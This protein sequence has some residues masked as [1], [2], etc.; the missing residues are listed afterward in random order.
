LKRRFDLIESESI[1]RT[2]RKNYL[3]STSSTSKTSHELPGIPGID[4]LPYLQKEGNVILGI[5]Q[6]NNL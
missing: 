1:M 2:L 6:Q 3:T 5:D 4:L